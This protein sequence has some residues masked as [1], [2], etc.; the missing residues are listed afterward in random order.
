MS[1][2]K[3]LRLSFRNT[4]ASPSM[5]ARSN[6][7]AAN[8]VGDPGEPIREVGARRLQ[9]LTSTPTSRPKV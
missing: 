5:S 9:T 1:A 4:T 6:G 7:E 2:P 8:H 3:S